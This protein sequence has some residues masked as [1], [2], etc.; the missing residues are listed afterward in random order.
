MAQQLFTIYHSYKKFL[1]NFERKDDT[2]RLYITK[3]SI[4][5]KVSITEAENNG[6][7]FLIITNDRSILKNIVENT[8]FMLLKRNILSFTIFHN[9]KIIYENNNF[10]VLFN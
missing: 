2:I 5:T 7:S 10:I 3:G 4:S 6:Y 1:F 8:Q 9:D